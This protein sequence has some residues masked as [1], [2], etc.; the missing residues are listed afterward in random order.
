MPSQEELITPAQNVLLRSL[1]D[2]IK[3]QDQANA[4]KE[5]IE[6]MDLA[7]FVANRME[8]DKD[9][10]PS[11]QNCTD[12]IDEAITLRSDNGQ[13]LFDSF[14]AAICAP[15]SKENPN[16][17]E[18][19]RIIEL[20]M[21][22]KDLDGEGMESVGEMTTAQKLY[23]YHKFMGNVLSVC[24]D[25]EQDESGNQKVSLKKVVAE[26]YLENVTK[27]VE[28]LI[29]RHKQYKTRLA[30]LDPTLRARCQSRAVDDIFDAEMLPGDRWTKPQ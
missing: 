4:D 8:D 30:N 15:R 23:E 16:G 12:A 29:N 24:R 11:M 28:M 1:F 13:C 14:V 27:E 3:N 25:G 7:K 26:S 21:K 2:S 10:I 9:N 5:F 6:D 20:A 19:A 22:G 17:S 18:M